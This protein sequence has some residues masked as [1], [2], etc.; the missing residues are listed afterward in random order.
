M[1]FCCFFI[2]ANFCR[3]WYLCKF[4][5]LGDLSTHLFG[6]DYTG[7]PNPSRS[8]AKVGFF[9]TLFFKKL[10]ENVALT[11]FIYVCVYTSTDTL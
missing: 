5:I 8:T 7:P 9:K 4:L 11:L 3:Q 2:F 10:L 1:C 6:L